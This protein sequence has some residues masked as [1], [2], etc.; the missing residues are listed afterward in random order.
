MRWILALATV[1]LGCASPRP[2][3]KVL[4]V[5]DADPL[6]RAETFQLEYE[7]RGGPAAS[8]QLEVRE[9]RVLDEVSFPFDLTVAPLEADA[10][11]VFEVIATSLDRAGAVVAQV[12]VRAGYAPNMGRTIRLH[13]DDRCRGVVCG[14]GRTCVQGACVANGEP[15]DAGVPSL[16]G[17]MPGPCEDD[18]DCD[19]GFVCNGRETCN[20]GTCVPGDRLDCSDRFPC[21][22]D[23]C[24]TGG[25]VHL[26]DDTACE[27]GEGGR[28]DPATGLA[29]PQSMTCTSPKAPTMTLAGFRS[30]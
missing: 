17:G 2:A 21:T 10:T 12:R 9:R 4:V 6:V 20:A 24:T 5:V 22:E 16:D 13:M 25:C 26:S 28:C 11:R 29:R 19:D 3:T 8:P 30:L 18:A 1:A 15:G 14:E 23:L 27:A 7:V